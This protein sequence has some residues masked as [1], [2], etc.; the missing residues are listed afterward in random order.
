MSRIQPIQV[1]LPEDLFSD[2][3]GHSSAAR[4]KVTLPKVIKQVGQLAGYDF[5]KKLTIPGS[6]GFNAMYENE[7]IKVGFKTASNRWLN[8]ADTLVKATDV[9]LVPY[10]IWDYAEGEEEAW[11]THLGMLSISSADLL[12]MIKKVRKAAE[13]DG[14]DP[15]G[16]HYIPVF[17]DEI[18]DIYGCAAGA[19]ENADSAEFLFDEPVE[20]DWVGADEEPYL[21]MDLEEEAEEE[22]PTQTMAELV[23]SAKEDL[24]KKLGVSVS[25][26]KLS[27]EM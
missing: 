7:A 1:R 10:F 8:T 9:I 18:Y 2:E 20:I 4:R 6:Y 22:T 3:G 13:Q 25:A 26:I 16:H 11:P 15:K 17:E 12:A 21:V 5:G 19:L 23:F 14:E 27:V 24:A